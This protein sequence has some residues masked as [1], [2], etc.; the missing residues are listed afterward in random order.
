MSGDG[1]VGAV[2]WPSHT[3]PVGISSDGTSTQSALVVFDLERAER[4]EMPTRMNAGA[5]RAVNADN[6]VIAVGPDCPR[7]RGDAPVDVGRAVQALAEETPVPLPYRT[8]YP[9]AAALAFNERD[10]LLHSDASTTAWT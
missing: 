1:R 6:W 7:W 3:K 5:G 2:L 9:H 4:I 8:I 10:R